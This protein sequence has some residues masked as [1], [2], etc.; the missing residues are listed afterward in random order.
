M[1]QWGTQGTNHPMNHSE[2]SLV[3]CL[4][5]IYTWVQHRATI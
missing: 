4:G 5:W 3:V 1:E 2:L